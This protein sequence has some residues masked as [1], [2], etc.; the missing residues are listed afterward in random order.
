MCWPEGKT[1]EAMLMFEI[2]LARKRSGTPSVALKTESRNLEK[3]LR[4]D[5][6]DLPS[7]R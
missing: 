2:I 7:K 4:T 1:S 6:D 3:E 5:D